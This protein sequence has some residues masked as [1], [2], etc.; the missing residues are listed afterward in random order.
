MNLI[1]R[2]QNNDY[3]FDAGE[4]IGQSILI[5]GL[6]MII[7]EN[8]YSL[9]TIKKFG[10]YYLTTATLVSNDEEICISGDKGQINIIKMQFINGEISVFQNVINSTYVTEE[11]D[12]SNKERKQMISELQENAKAKAIASGKYR[13]ETKTEP[14]IGMTSE[15]VI[16][17]TWGKPDRINK[18]T[19][20]WGV[21]EQWCYKDN[22]YVYLENG[23]VVAIQ[24]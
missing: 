24:E 20:A 12:K 23:S 1:F 9:R 7:D 22:R 13:K 4:D 17:S 15:E 11:R 2:V 19:Y 14:L 21:T 5:D 16:A 6:N 10:N 3:R 8:Q 18:T